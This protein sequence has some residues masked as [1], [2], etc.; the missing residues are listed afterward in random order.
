MDVIP[1]LDGWCY[2]LLPEA[3]CLPG[4]LSP[5]Y[6]QCPPAGPWGDSLGSGGLVMCAVYLGRDNVQW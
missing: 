3:V 1:L 4:G 5:W 6:H 2:I